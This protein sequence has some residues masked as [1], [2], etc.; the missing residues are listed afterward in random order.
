M[1]V[2]QRAGEGPLES[3]PK[4]FD[5]CEHQLKCSPTKECGCRCGLIIYMFPNLYAEA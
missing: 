5:A 1:R 2:S 4:G 3:L